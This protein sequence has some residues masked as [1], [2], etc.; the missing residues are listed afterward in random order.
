MERCDFVSVMAVIRSY[1]SEDWGLNQ[2]DFLYLIFDS[3]V[4]SEAGMDFD[5]DN[6]LVCR[7]LKGSAKVSPK[8]SGYYLTDKRHRIQMATDIYENLL[9]KMSDSAMAVEKIYGLIIGDDSISERMKSELVQKYPCH[10]EKEDA[11]FFTNALCFGLEREFVKRDARTNNLITSG[12]LSPVV[13]DFIFGNDVPKPCRHFCGREGEIRQLHS[14]L[15]EHGKVFVHGIAGIGK[16]E[17]AKAY[18][19]QYKKEYTNTLYITYSGSLY[20]DVTDLDFADDLPDESEEERFRRH[21]RFLR[22]LKSDT[23]LVIDNF[24]VPATKDSF[25]PVMMKYRCRIVFTT[26]NRME[27][28]PSM[29]LGEIPD[30]SALLGLMGKYYSEADKHTHILEQIIDAVHSHTLAVELAAR[31]LDKGIMEPARLLSKLREEKTSLDSA[32]KISITKDGR[33]TKETYYGH[34]HTLFSLFRLTNAEQDVMRNMA[35][36]PM[37][38]IPVRRLADWL[39]LADLNTVND[40]IEN[41]FLTPQPG[42]SVTLHPMVQ[43]ITVTDLKPSIARCRTLCEKLQGIC[44]MHGLDISFHRLLFA[45]VENIITIAEKDDNRFFLLFLENVFPYMDKYHY[46]PGMRVILA[47][48]ER[49]IGQTPGSTG[50]SGEP[51]QRNDRALLLDYKASMEKTP[52][53]AIRLEKDALALLTETDE[54]NALLA[55]NIHANLGACYRMAGQ[56]DK[57]REHIEN[58][59]S[60]LKKHGLVYMHDSAVLTANY[61]ALLCDMGEPETAMKILQSV[62]REIGQHTTEASGD[63]TLLTEAM[64]TVC[65]VQG[66][67]P[68]ATEHYKKAMAI[69]ETVWDGEPEMLEAKQQEILENYAEAGIG[70]GQRLLQQ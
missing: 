1:V 8:I 56:L 51:D 21:N 70:I 34:I 5:F 44:L 13:S 18:A 61:A 26:R 48:M 43:E 14:L 41:G 54:K 67:I 31:L 2:I 10:N 50:L 49:L 11:A 22:T 7:W 57:V 42:R 23:L 12:N 27:H 59:A 62:A 40:L 52:S 17:F 64:G 20:H 53:K 28:Y 69:Y 37:T 9:P 65:M 46:E 45:T 33:P 68:D 25:L 47:E 4:S 29:Q 16:S 38:G 3:F 19:A 6:G 58:A 60:L 63:Y 39:G 35:L 32:D 66:K 36:I 30:K 15:A 24:N 55:A